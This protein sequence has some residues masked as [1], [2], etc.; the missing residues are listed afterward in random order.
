MF[1]RTWP[2]PAKL[3]LMLR[4]T[5]RRADG[6]HE[7]QTVFQFLDFS[8]QLTFKLLA[9]DAIRRESHLPDVAEEDDLVIRAASL[10]KKETGTS[11]GVSIFLEKKL[12]MGGGVGGGSSDAATTLVALNELWQTGVPLSRLREIGVQLGADVPVFLYGRSAWAEGIGDKLSP[13]E[14]PESWYLV[15]KPPCFVSTSEIFC[16]QQLTRAA[17]RITIRD[18]LAGETENYCLPVVK[19]RYPEVAEAMR[20]LTQFA[21]ARLT[22]TGA[23]IFAAFTTEQ[24]ARAVLEKVPDKYFAFVAKGMNRS[25]LFGDC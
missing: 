17:S 4:I 14:L 19:K 10:L 1:H 3:N 7:L 21:A 9:E 2:A 18:F 13:I 23:C 5:G 24:E 16:D 6:Y 25:P 8:D 22:G 15:L 12:P 11:K 20:W